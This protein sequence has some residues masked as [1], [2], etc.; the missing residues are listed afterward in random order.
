M[1]NVCR[2]CCDALPP[3]DGVGG[4]PCVTRGSRCSP[5]VGVGLSKHHPRHRVCQH[6]K[7][8]KINNLR[9]PTWLMF[10]IQSLM[11][12]ADVVFS[13]HRHWLS[14]FLQHDSGQLVMVL[15]L[16]LHHGHGTL[17]CWKSRRRQH[18][19]HLNLNSRHIAFLFLFLIF[20]FLCTV[21]AVLCTIHFK[22]LIMIMINIKYGQYYYYNDAEIGLS[23]NDPH[24]RVCQHYKQYKI[25]VTLLLCK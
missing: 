2:L 24:H 4:A 10:Y 12:P 17:F 8:H 25:W 15:F 21:T 5:A 14:P 11:Y 19:Q 3:C 16:Q 22:F 1:S 9:R 23:E 18:C 13:Q 7:P 20:S 6:C